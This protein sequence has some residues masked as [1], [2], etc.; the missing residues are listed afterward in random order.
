MLKKP[1]KFIDVPVK[2]HAALLLNPV[3]KAY[4]TYKKKDEEGEEIYKLNEDV[5]RILTVEKSENTGITH[6]I[7]IL[8]DADFSWVIT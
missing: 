8:D 1:P 2:N 6:V 7:G 5:F 4:F 3:D